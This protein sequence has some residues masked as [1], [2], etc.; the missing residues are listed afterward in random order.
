MIIFYFFI[1][2]FML[3]SIILFIVWFVFS[4]H[5]AFRSPECQV[6]LMFLNFW[7]YKS[8]EARK[9]RLLPLTELDINKSLMSPLSSLIVLLICACLH[10][11]LTRNDDELITIY[12]LSFICTFDYTLH[13]YGSKF[14]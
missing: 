9:F 11:S 1:Y 4:F 3:G 5:V 12:M 8:L 10:I 13:I 6:L 14:V 2:I 7:D